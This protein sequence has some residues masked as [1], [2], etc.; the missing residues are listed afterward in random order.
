MLTLT[1]DPSKLSGQD[2]TRYIAE[3]FAD[4]RIYMKR[5]LGVNPKYIR[6]IE[7]QKNGNPHLHILLDCYLKQDWVSGAWSAL[8]G[9][10]IVDIRRVDMHRASHYLS[11]YLTK[12]MLMSAPKRTRRVTTSRTIKLNPKNDSDPTWTLLYMPIE[13]LYKHY[14]CTANNVLYDVEGNVTAFE[15]F[16]PME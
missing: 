7:S 4:F 3:V 13:I 2:S 1:L 6:V 16:V 12:E 14:L 5:R 11:K 9:G 15:S 8:G 10:K